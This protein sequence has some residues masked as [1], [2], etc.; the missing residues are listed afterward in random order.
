VAEAVS[1]PRL[2]GPE[3]AFCFCALW[4]VAYTPPPAPFRFAAVWG[5]LIVADTGGGG[6][7]A[8]GVRGIGRRRR[9]RRVMAMVANEA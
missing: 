7:G 6:G 8:G 5:V 2:A 1:I 9:R 3:F 4:D